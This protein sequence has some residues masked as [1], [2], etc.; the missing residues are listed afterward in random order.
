MDERPGL[1]SWFKL[2]DYI[3]LVNLFLIA[4]VEKCEF[5]L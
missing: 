3:D 1:S 5:D 2:E 4:I